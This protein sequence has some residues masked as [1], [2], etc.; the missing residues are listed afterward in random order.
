MNE[1][2]R[3]YVQ[4]FFAG[5]LWGTIGIFATLLGDMGLSSS[6]ISFF[7]LLSAS[8]LLALVLLVKGK[9][10]SLFRISKKGLISCM[11]IG[12]ISQAIYNIFYM[13]AVNMT[14]MS[15]AAVLLYTSPV[16]VMLLSRIFFKEKITFLKFF[17]IILNILGCVLVVT[18]GD[19]SGIKVAFIGI[20]FGVMAGFT[21]GLM[22]IFSRLGADDENAFTSAFYGLFF[23][24]VALFFIARPY[25]GVSAPFTMNMLLVIIGFGLIP[26]A[27][28]YIIYFGGLSKVKETSIIPV[29]CSVENVAASIFGFLVFHES[30]T[31]LKVVGVA[32]VFISIMVINL[33]KKA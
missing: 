1:N 6:E 14:G 31:F 11:L 9:G 16:F 13:G 15:T 25:Q 4:V 26:S 19:F 22:P 23:G 20:V 32:L 29:L 17:A 18:G 3:G 30:F 21:Y 5:F 27:I 2:N 10:L 33:K 24:M 28:A 7:R 8:S 12:F